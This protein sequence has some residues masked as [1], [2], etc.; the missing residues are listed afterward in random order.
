[1]LIVKPLEDKSALE[2]L[3]AQQPLQPFLQSW[4]WGE[5][6]S[7]L[8]RRI[9]RL[10]VV[11]DDVVVA[12]ALIIEH[13][14]ILGKSYLY[15]PR[16]PVAATAEALNLLLS[17]LPKFGQTTGAMYLKIDFPR[18]A[19]PFAGAEIPA[20][21]TLGTPLQDPATL[22][23]NVQQ[24]EDDLLAHFHS[25]TR[26]NIRLAEKRGV[27]VR[28]GT[29]DKD[30]EVF[31]DLQKEMSARQGIRLH[32]EK[33]YREMFDALSK[34]NMVSFVI[35]E[36]KGQPIVAN[37]IIWHHQTATFNHGGSS[38]AHKDVMA[39]YLVQWA[40]IKEAKRRGM[41][42]Y[43]LRGIAPSG[44]PDHKLAG[45]T[46][47][48]LGFGGQS[49]EFPAANCILQPQWYWAYRMAKRMRGGTDE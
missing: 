29:S 12:A 8:G 3:L 42:D 14:L 41:H 27:T 1:M 16:G 39:A 9:W 22:V 45:V 30:F 25:K 6:Q 17:E 46:R 18:Y 47:F 48:K 19:F 33:Y 40:T 10:G 44:Q 32:A 38:S 26:Y 34:Q 31:M 43:D 28:W 37:E 13:Q 36:Y 15:C 20:P 35:A 24:T 7:G 49:I 23:V 5:F 4:A 11:D 2:A 21:F